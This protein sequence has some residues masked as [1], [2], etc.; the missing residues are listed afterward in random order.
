MRSLGAT[1][2][3]VSHRTERASVSLALTAKRYVPGARGIPAIDPSAPILTPAG[4]RPAAS[5]QA[6]TPEPPRARSLT[7]KGTPASDRGVATGVE[8]I[9]GCRRT[10]SVNCF[11]VFFPAQFAGSSTGSRIST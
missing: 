7:L 2:S 8:T 10:V 9:Q 6:K 4:G 5:S 1:L 11:S 3:S